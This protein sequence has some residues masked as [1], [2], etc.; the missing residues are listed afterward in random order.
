MNNLYV[1]HLGTNLLVKDFV[2]LAFLLLENRRR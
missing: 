1:H 2:P